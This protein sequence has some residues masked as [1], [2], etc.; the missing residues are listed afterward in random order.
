MKSL[1]R[2]STHT[3]SDETPASRVWPRLAFGA[4]GAVL[5]TSTLALVHSISSSQARAL[6]F[7]HVTVPISSTNT[8]VV[9]VIPTAPKPTIVYQ[10]VITIPPLLLPATTVFIP[11]TNAPVI[12]RPPAAPT[13]ALGPSPATAV[14]ATVAPTVAPG[15]AVP[16]TAGPTVVPPTAVPATA[17]P[18]VVPATAVPKPAGPTV[19]PATAVPSAM[20]V[21]VSTGQVPS[22]TAQATVKP[23]PSSIAPLVNIQ[24]KATI[25]GK[26]GAAKKARSRPKTANSLPLTR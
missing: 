17:L 14:P 7:S 12:T 18:T 3:S 9:K 6:P 4:A 15:T 19:V 2:A 25:A 26:K 20:F 16:A 8:L 22:M 1:R 13:T 21:V 24:P 23:S 5:V 10:P 11:T